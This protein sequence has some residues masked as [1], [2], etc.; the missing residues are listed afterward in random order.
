MPEGEGRTENLEVRETAP[1]RLD[2]YLARHLSL[3]RSR[4][5]ALIEEGCVTVDGRTP[6]KSDVVQPG[7]RITVAI[8]SPQPATA[9]A[10]PIPLDIRY[11]D[12]ALLVVNKPTGMVVH[13][14][15][16][17][18]TGTLVNALLHAVSDLSGIGGV[19]RPGI[20]HRLDRDTSGLILVAKTE[21]AQRKLSDA[22][23]HRQIRRRYVTMTWGHLPQQSLTVDAP[24]GR[25][26]KDRK[27]MAVVPL[28]RR[29]VTRLRVRESWLAAELLEVRLETGRTHQIRVHL[30]HIGHPVVGDRVYGAGWERGMS[31]PGHRWALELASRIPRQFLHAW[32]LVFPHPTTGLEVRCRAPL[33]HDLI[34][35]LEWARS[36]AA[37]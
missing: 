23:K 30:A 15:P 13:P 21:H 5:A 22:F 4:A 28:G 12:E 35:A 31:G 36:H 18:L 8:P 16:G 27:R 20:V 33:A 34:P 25:H 1:E 17:H 24:I 11:E 6:R 7:Q 10:E 26:P 37:S 29:A 32:E 14:A 3:S 9:T 19:L 2:V